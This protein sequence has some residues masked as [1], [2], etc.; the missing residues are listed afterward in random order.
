MTAPITTR[1]QA[2]RTMNALR[3]D[4]FYR[5]VTTRGILTGEFLGIEV[6]HGERAI[7]LRSPVGA[8]ASV[9]VGEIISI[10]S[11]A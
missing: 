5:V 8:T 1:P 2:H 4:T 10:D 7:L 6:P 3:R 9:A 11:T